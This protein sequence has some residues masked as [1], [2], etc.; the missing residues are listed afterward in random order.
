M[1]S[2]EHGPAGPEDVRAAGKDDSRTADPDGAPPTARRSAAIVVNPAKVDVTTLRRVVER[3]ETIHGWAPS[4]W[5]PTAAADDGRGA[6]RDAAE[7]RPE[8]ILVA[9]GDGTLRSAAEELSGSGI[10]LGL[11][12]VGT[13][14]LFARELRLPLNDLAAAVEIAFTGRNRPIDVGVVE[15]ERPDGEKETKAFLVMTGI[16]VDAHMAAHTNEA[17]KRRIGWLAYTD[18]IARSVFGNRQF[19]LVY[20]LDDKPEVAT[21]AHTVIVGNSGSL[22]AG[23]L[24]LPAATVDDGLLD[25]VVFRPGRG[26]GW[27][28]IGYRLTFNRLLHRTRVGR[29]LVRLTPRS[30]AIRWAQ[31]TRMSVRFDT[32]QEIQLDGDPSGTVVGAVITVQ[33]H[34]LLIRA[35]GM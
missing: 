26:S 35:P 1:S 3:A 15:F 16:G 12:A 32:P 2:T 29:Q 8:L 28:N 30:R 5:F 33:H 31:A 9:G 25:A 11:L 23:L 27:T 6:V 22:P 10:P 7:L 17:L 20:R 18:P 13:A 4:T 34:G 19:D 21:R 14:N 24:L